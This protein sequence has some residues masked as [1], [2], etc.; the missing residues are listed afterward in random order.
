[1]I[2]GV[3]PGIRGALAYYDGHAPS[4]RDMPTRKQ[5]INGSLRDVI[6]EQA[7]CKLLRSARANASILVLEQVGGMPGQSG[8]AAF[9]FGHGVGLIRG[10][11]VTLGY[12]IEHVPAARWT[13]ALGLMHSDKD[14]HRASAAE[15]WSEHAALFSRKKDADRADA[16]LIALYGFQVF[17]PAK[18]ESL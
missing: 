13:G 15:R 17:A 5:M 6:D 4:I 9:T 12:Q 10:I 7:L 14:G 1:M 18:G 2:L 8:P 11:G 3:D 16:A